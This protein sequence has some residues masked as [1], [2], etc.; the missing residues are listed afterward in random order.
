MVLFPHFNPENSRSDNQTFI[1]TGKLH[2]LL[3]RSDKLKRS[4][5]DGVQGPYRRQKR[6]QSTREHRPNHFN[7]RHSANQISHR[8]AMRS[9]E[10]ASVYAIPNL[11]FQKPAGYQW[12]IPQ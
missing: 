9:L 6:L 10:A 1:V 2:V 8:V 7:Y 5:V 3:L 11:A 4:E 12:L